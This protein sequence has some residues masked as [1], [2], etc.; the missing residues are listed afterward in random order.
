[1]TVRVTTRYE[2]NGDEVAD[3]FDGSSVGFDVEPSG[4]L[5]IHR[6]GA[7]KDARLWAAY[8]PGQWVMVADDRHV[9]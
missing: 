3:E 5:V 2:S 7:G 4:A 1:M 8:A 6:G 9:R